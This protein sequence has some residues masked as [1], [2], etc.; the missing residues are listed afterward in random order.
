MVAAALPPVL[1]ALAVL[2]WMRAESVAA[3][4]AAPWL[5]FCAVISFKVM[6]SASRFFERESPSR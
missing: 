2:G 3:F 1:A 6:F 5:V 4:T